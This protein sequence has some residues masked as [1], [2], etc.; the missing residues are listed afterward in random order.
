MPNSAQVNAVSKNVHG[1]VF[2]PLHTFMP[3]Y[4]YLTK[5]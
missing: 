4:G 2:N 5:S 3:E 1:V